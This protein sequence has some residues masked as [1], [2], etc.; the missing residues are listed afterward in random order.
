[1]V[2]SWVKDKKQTRKKISMRPDWLLDPLERKI[3]SQNYLVT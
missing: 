3:G 1:M 2:G